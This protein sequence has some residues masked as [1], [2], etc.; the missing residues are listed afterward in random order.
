MLLSHKY[1]FLFVHI[2]KT[3]GTSIR[4]VLVRRIRNDPY[5]LIQILCSRLSGLSGHRLGIKFPRHAK[6][7]AALEMLPADSFRS[8]FKFA[9]VRNPWDLQVSSYHHIQQERP[10]LI[11][12]LDGFEAFLQ[13]K[14]EGERD[15]HYILDAS[16]E[17]QWHSLIDLN[18]DC[19]VDFIGRYENLSHDFAGICSRIGLQPAPELPHKRKA[20]AREDY[21][22]YYTNR[23]FDLIEKHFGLDIENLGYTFDQGPG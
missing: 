18:H 21:R 17:P 14:L 9:F 10:Q 7:I 23:S 6:V 19:R 13:W 11:R 12:H 20:A 4:S 8:L 16:T 1:N 15:Y 2:A 5:R 22:R 3:G